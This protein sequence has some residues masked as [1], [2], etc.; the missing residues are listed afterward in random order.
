R[1]DYQTPPSSFRHVEPAP[2]G[3]QLHTRIV[4]APNAVPP[5]ADDFHVAVPRLTTPTGRGLVINDLFLYGHE[6]TYSLALATMELEWVFAPGFETLVYL[7]RSVTA[8][9][10]VDLSLR[11]HQVAEAPLL[12]L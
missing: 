3:W 2:G 9:G 1:Y 6:Q 8:E 7:R 10:L 11:A 12:S 4:G 5:I